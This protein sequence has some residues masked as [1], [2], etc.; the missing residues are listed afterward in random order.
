[1]PTLRYFANRHLTHELPCRTTW[2]RLSCC[3]RR[4][5]KSKASVLMTAGKLCMA[6]SPPVATSTPRNATAL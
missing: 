5:G 2:V 1:M 4:H 3:H 6:T